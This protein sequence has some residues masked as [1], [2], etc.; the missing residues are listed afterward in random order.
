MGNG[1][2]N[3]QREPPSLP[4]AVAAG[5]AGPPPGA[6]AAPPGPGKLQPTAQMAN[7]VGS[8][9]KRKAAEI[10]AAKA[11]DSETRTPRSRR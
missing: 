10:A 6:A 9:K 11:E 1:G 4:S 2:E 3:K 5:G 8:G 7:G